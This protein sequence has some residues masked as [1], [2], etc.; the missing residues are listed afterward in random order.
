[1]K[2]IIKLFTI[3]SGIILPNF[4]IA[5]SCVK[6][7]N[8]QQDNNDNDETSSKWNK[9][10][11]FANEYKLTY[12]NIAKTYFHYLNKDELNYSLPN[13][14][15]IQFK[16]FLSFVEYFYP[17][18]LVQATLQK[19]LKVQIDDILNK[20]NN[21]NLVREIFGT[22]NSR[23]NLFK[24]IEHIR[25]IAEDAIKQVYNNSD[26]KDG[27]NTI[28]EEQRNKQ[29]LQGLIQELKQSS[30]ISN[31]KAARYLTDAYKFIS[32]SI[33]HPDNNLL[34]DF[35]ELKNLEVFNQTQVDTFINK[36]FVGHSHH[37][38]H[39]SLNMIV[40][41]YWLVELLSKILN[42]NNYSHSLKN[43]KEK[44][45]QETNAEL[46]GQMLDFIKNLEKIFEIVTPLLLQKEI[47]DNMKLQ[48]HNLID[49]LSKMIEVL[50]LNKKDIFIGIKLAD[51]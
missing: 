47:M 20:H 16:P 42:N 41:L 27:F 26:N 7:H 11:N 45:K 18:S 23:T 36:H 2:K 37:H 13:D 9:F 44:V 3:G 31:N 25:F 33:R 39:S 46:K 34:K 50:N 19:D 32:N 24:V 40:E 15:Y 35:N 17:N 21:E 22:N 28:N 10:A 29:N 6:H 51:E 14:I 38:S 1:M 4:F 49:L 43:M 30:I 5:A 48:Y 12:E 8:E